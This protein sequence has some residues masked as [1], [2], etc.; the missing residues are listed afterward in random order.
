MARVQGEDRQNWFVRPDGSSIRELLGS[1]AQ[2]DWRDIVTPEMR[3]QYQRDGVLY[4]PQLIHPEWLSVIEQG[5]KRNMDN[6]GYNAITMHQGLPGEYH[7]D[8]DN[9]HV[10]PEYRYLMAHSPIAD[11][12]QYLI[13]TEELWF[14]HDQIFVKRGGNN[15]PTFWH[16]DLPYWILDGMKFGS[17][18]ITLDP[19]PKEECLEF[20]PGS[21]LGTQYGGTTFNPEDPTEP[22]FPSLPRIPNI[23]AERDK[24]DIVSYEITPGDVLI[25]H[26]GTL[27][28]GGATGTGKQ[29]RTITL[30][31]YGDDAVLDGR[32]EREGETPAPHYPGLNL[33][34]EPG[35]KVRDDRFP[36]LRPESDVRV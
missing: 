26:P 11:I 7:M 19:V 9:F 12:M 2:Q 32:F 21:H 22:V 6:P 17:M 3:E 15:M 24:W 30:R 23:E 33:R 16:Q 4:I 34:F 20:V 29:R 1:S 25:L 27:H 14:F 18:W 10:N 8:Y 5:M 36:K 28:G 31:F 35:E 13:D